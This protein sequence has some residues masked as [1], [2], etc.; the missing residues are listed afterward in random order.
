MFAS[1]GILVVI[2]APIVNAIGFGAY[3]SILAA[4]CCVA[5]SG[6]LAYVACLWRQHA[7]E[8]GAGEA[9][10]AGSGWE[11]EGCQHITCTTNE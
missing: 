4:L 9:R 10:A 6:S 8:A 7:R 2:S 3:F 5:C 1:A 11:G